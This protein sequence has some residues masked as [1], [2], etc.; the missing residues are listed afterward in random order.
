[1]LCMKPIFWKPKMLVCT[2]GGE[3]GGD[4]KILNSG[5]IKYPI[6]PYKKTGIATVKVPTQGRYGGVNLM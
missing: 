3:G 4:L 1:M 6:M 5:L 2:L